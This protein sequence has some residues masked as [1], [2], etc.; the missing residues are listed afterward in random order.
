MRLMQRDIVLLPFPFSDMEGSKVRPALIISNDNFNESPA[1]CIML[2]L[3][4]VIKPDAC[5]I[6]LSPEDLAAGDLLKKSR[7]KVDKAFSVEKGL[8]LMKIGSLGNAKFSEIKGL[9]FSLF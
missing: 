5:S 2:P 7:V 8:V 6:I 1:D 9:F 4:S 3:T